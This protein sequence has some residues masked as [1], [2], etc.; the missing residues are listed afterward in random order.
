MG[1]QENVQATKNLY[2][3]FDR[4]DIDAIIDS[5]SDD[6]DWGWPSVATEVPWFGVVRG[7]PAVRK[8]F[9]VIAAEADIH[10]F[11]QKD[12]IGSDN[13]V[14]VTWQ[15]ELTVKKT[16]KRFTDEGMHLWVFDSQGKISTYRGYSDSAAAQA[17]WRG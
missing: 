2:A 9:D 1:A 6:V 16:G 13:M 12:F 14:A 8:F 15:G 11:E 7:H 5:L 3:A 17:A 10:R 4:G